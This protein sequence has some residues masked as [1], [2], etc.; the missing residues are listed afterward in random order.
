ML[1]IFGYPLEKFYGTMEEYFLPNRFAFVSTL[2]A[3]YELLA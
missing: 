1:A 3:Q 2:L